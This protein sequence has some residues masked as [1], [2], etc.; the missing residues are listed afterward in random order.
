MLG[1]GEGGVS[2][3]GEC[4]CVVGGGEVGCGGRGGGGGCIWMCVGG[5]YWG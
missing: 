5:M 3:V 1:V 2:G 4:G